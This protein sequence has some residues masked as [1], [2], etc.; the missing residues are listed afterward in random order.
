MLPLERKQSIRNRIYEQG[1]V[2]IETLAR[3]LHV[4]DMTI[5]RDLAV[6]E[7]EGKVIRTHGG[8][9]AADG[10]IT[11][12]P[13]ESKVSKNKTEKQKIAK[14]AADMV[15]ENAK[16]LLDSG[17]TTL[18][19]A[20]LL[21][22]REDLV[23]VTNDIKISMEFLQSRS[24]VICTGG[25]LQAQIGSFLGPH[26][27]SLLKQLTVDLLFLGA[28]AIDTTSGLTA[29]TM[30]KA[31]VKQLMVHAARQKWVVA[32]NSKFGMRSFSQVCTLD[33]LSGLI[34]NHLIEQEQEKFEEIINVKNAS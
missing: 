31:L 21:K 4:S 3:D 11:E 33:Q 17:T 30:E 6:L 13:Y 34:T 24:Q 18:E 29:P 28:H 19:I 7:G 9:V 23:V 5:R 16:I 10:L 20:K 2:E 27:Q 32:D 8:A 15:P 1:K 14:T 22:W 25:E 26:V 12:T